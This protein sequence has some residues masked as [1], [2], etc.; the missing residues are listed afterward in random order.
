[1]SVDPFASNATGKSSPADRH[2]A[3]TPAD[4]DLAIIPRAL[5]ANTAGDVVVRDAGGVDVTYSVEAGVII[6]I[7]AIQV[8]TGTTATVIGLY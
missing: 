7:R 8:R 5:Y 3:I 4:S 1:M 2:F 6:P